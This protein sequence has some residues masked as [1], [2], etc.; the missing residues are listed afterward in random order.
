MSIGRRR[1]EVKEV[2]HRTHYP[3]SKKNLFETA[4]LDPTRDW[5]CQ[6]TGAT[7]VPEGASVLVRIGSGD[8][9][10]VI[11]GNQVIGKISGHEGGELVSAFARGAKRSGIP[12]LV[13]T[14]CAE[15]QS[16]TL[17]FCVAGT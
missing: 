15:N 17:R 13:Q 10:K 9:V 4:A 12:A 8:H 7:A 6:P 16:I 5:R 3:M 1:S 11:W 14:V 2:R